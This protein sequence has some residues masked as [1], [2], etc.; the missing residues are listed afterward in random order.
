MDKRKLADTF[1]ERLE[2]LLERSRQSQSAFAESI[3]IDRSAL[4]STRYICPAKTAT[5]VDPKIV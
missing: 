1:H 2:S 5:R 4:L 3:G